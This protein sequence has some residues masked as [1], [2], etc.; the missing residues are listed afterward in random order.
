MAGGFSEIKTGRTDNRELVRELVEHHVRF[1][2]AKRRFEMQRHDWY[3]VVALAVR[4][5]LI[6]RMV[7]TSARLD[8][9]KRKRLYYLSMEFLIGRSLQNNLH[10]LGVMEWCRAALAEQGVDLQ[11]LF[12][13]EPDAALGNGG[14]GR[15]AA[16]FLDSMATLNLAGYG[17]GINYEFGL[18]RQEIREGYQ[19]ERPDN[20]QRETSPWLVARPEA[21]CRIPV[22]GHIEHRTDRW[23]QYR[24]VWAERRELIGVPSD[25]P[26]S[27]YGGQTVNFVRLYS[28]RSSDEF[29]MQIFNNGDYVKAVEQ[30]ILSESISKVL[31][32]SDA[33][34]AGRELR[35]V[36]EYFFVA[37]AVG[38]IVRN[39]IARGEEL[40]ALPETVAIQLNDTHPA[41]AIAEL[42]RLLVDVYQMRWEQA[43]EI[44][45]A[46]FAYTNHTLLPEALEHWPASLLERV[47]PRHFQIICEIDRRFQEQVTLA[48]GY[49]SQRIARMAIVEPGGERRVRMAH[50]A[51]VGSH[52]VNGVSELHS[53]LLKQRLAADFHALWPERFSNQTNGVTQ[54][55][56]L[57][58]ANPGLSSLLDQTIGQGWRTEL[59]QLAGLE[60][61]AE[62]GEFQLRL[63]AVKRENKERLA[64]LVNRLTQIDVDPASMFD[65]QAKRIHEYKRQLLMALGIIHQYLTLVEDG[66]EPAAPRTFLLAGKAA[67]G[68]REAR[69]IIKLINNL[70]EVINS[71][72]RTRGLLK[73]AFL[74]DYRVSLAENIFPAADLSEQISTAGMEAS[75]TG[76]MKFAMNGA[77]TVGTLDGA[78]VEIRDAVGADNIFIFGLT[79]EQ[80]SELMHGDY[81]PRLSYESDP[82]VRRLVDELGSDRF[83]P[84][85]PGLFG[86]L[87]D[88]LLE[89]DRYFHL[90]DLG[91]YL[92]VQAIVGQQFT[93]RQVWTRKAILNIARIGRFSS[94]RTVSQYARQIW[95][96]L[97]P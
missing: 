12:E 22:Y 17:Y 15:L 6:E 84:R 71:D 43:W 97:P 41:L 34:Q 68:Y 60:R 54:R 58:I 7:R 95:R 9:D 45:V 96:M 19:H 57:L 37:C 18:F 50:L 94:D 82:R 80:I 53:Q 91:A 21:A 44:C 30:K 35:V 46:T 10:N 74:P 27:G 8:R 20:W 52:S 59:E 90:A 11:A 78:N 86:A 14:L 47:V 70:A 64:T 25:L 81:Q 73:V 38:D 1:T 89:R 48:L 75:G 2:L 61:Y 51:I 85:E 76:N 28:A 16:C 13:E 39:F 56:W 79:A 66:I 83:C 93:D 49:D 62:D 31:Y 3:R 42:M 77:L 67:P 87:R 5:L 88:L 26:I 24:P 40:E 55:R 63:N 29:D 4:D 33:V 65:I 36:Q 23:G 32:P 92:E 69:M 72:P